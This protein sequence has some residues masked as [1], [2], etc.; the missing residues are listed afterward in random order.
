M[1]RLFGAVGHFLWR[2]HGIPRRRIVRLSL[3]RPENWHECNSAILVGASGDGPSVEPRTVG[4]DDD[5]DDS[6]DPVVVTGRRASRAHPLT[7]ARKEPN[8]PVSRE[9]AADERAADER[10]ADEHGFADPKNRRIPTKPRINS[11]HAARLFRALLVL[12]NTDVTR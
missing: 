6:D 8:R 10:A 7:A 12:T 4:L 3:F 1:L 11:R 2:A 9:R 5:S